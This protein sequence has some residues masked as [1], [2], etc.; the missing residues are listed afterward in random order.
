VTENTL[1]IKVTQIPELVWSARKAM[2][3]VLRR[4][5][6]SES[7]PATARRLREIAAMFEAGQ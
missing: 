5:A 4:E 6:E 2:A 7:S 3:D 1:T